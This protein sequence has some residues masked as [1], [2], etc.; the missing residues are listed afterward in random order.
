MTAGL[1]FGVKPHPQFISGR[2]KNSYACSEVSIQLHHFKVCE[3]HAINF[4]AGEQAR[5]LTAV[6]G[7]M[8]AKEQANSIA[9]GSAGAQQ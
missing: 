6:L 7:S 8:A 9:E 4:G 3:I 2:K 5:L 1:I